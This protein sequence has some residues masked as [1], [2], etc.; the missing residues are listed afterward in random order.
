MNEIPNGIKV[1]KMYCW[2]KSFAKLVEDTRKSDS[3]C[4]LTS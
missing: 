3:L 4:L 1:I 2:E